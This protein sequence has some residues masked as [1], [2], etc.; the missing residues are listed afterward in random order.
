[1]CIR[2]SRSAR[3]STGH[4]TAGG[5]RSENRDVRTQIEKTLP[6]CGIAWL[7]ACRSTRR[8]LGDR[9]ADSRRRA[10]IE[11]CVSA[12]GP[13]NRVS[14]WSKEYVEP[15]GNWRHGVSLAIERIWIAHKVRGRTVQRLC[16]VHR[17]CRCAFSRLPGYGCPQVHDASAVRARRKRNRIAVLVQRKRLHRRCA[18]LGTDR[19]GDGGRGCLLYTSRCV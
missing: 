6:V 16:Q 9:E 14:P 4:R 11:A 13:A 1:M 2:D 18:W 17:P 8:S 19:H 3:L 10:R 7:D 15:T 12:V 5:N